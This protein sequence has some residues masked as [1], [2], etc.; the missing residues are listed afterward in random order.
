MSEVAPNGPKLFRL[1]GCLCPQLVLEPPDLA[2][3]QLVSRAFLALARDNGLWR[4]RCLQESSYLKILNHR[5]SLGIRPQPKPN[6]PIHYEH[7][8]D[9]TRQWARGSVSPKRPATPAAGDSITDDDRERARIMANWDPCFP[10]EPVSWYDEYLLRHGPIVVN[11]MQL[12]RTANLSSGHFVEARGVAL[13][14]PDNSHLDGSCR[15]TLLAVSPLNDGSVC[16][17]DVNGTQTGKRGSIVAQSRPGILFIDGPDADNKRRSKRINSG[18]TESV[19]VDSLH[20][21]AFFAVQ[22]RKC[23]FSAVSDT[24]R[25]VCYL[26]IG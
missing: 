17:W 9:I 21:R 13:Y 25:D 3:V 2:S 24:G 19:S 16:L 12:P 15:E 10:S 8:I 26:P 1:T 22:G 14:R 7:T 18:V 5:R 20:H 6:A 4:Q 23:T 11:W